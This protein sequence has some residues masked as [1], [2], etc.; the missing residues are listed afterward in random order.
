VQIAGRARAIQN[1]SDTELGVRTKEF[2]DH[3][4][5]VQDS[6]PAEEVRIL[7]VED[8][9]TVA[10]AVKAYLKGAGRTVHH[11]TTA[12]KAEKI[13]ATEPIDIVLL[14][15]ILPD[16]DGR[17]LLVQM[18]E[19]RDTA[20]V[21]VIIMSGMEGAVAKAEC[22]AV[23]AA[24]FLEKP[25]NPK[26]LRAA[27]AKHAR[28]RASAS[29]T[30][31][32]PGGSLAAR[33]DLVESF[34]KLKP[35]VESG[36]SVAAT[37]LRVGDIDQIEAT[38]GEAGTDRLLYAVASRV[39]GSLQGSTISGRWERSDVVALMPECTFKEAKKKV[40]EGLRG[41]PGSADMKPIE[42]AGLTFALGTGVAVAEPGQELREVV[43]AAE[44]ALLEAR[45]S[46]QGTAL[47]EEP[48][49]LGPPRV[50]LVEDDRVTATLI[51][52]RLVREGLEVM[53]FLN[54]ED[55]YAWAVESS[56]DLAILDVKVPGMDGFEL[57][58]RL[59]AMPKLDDVPIV[60]LTGLG[61]E[62]DV[63]RGLEL[64]ANDYML[65][66]FSPTELLARIRRLLHASGPEEVVAP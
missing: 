59:R 20:S 39:L 24:E 45:Q 9:R 15:L 65:K 37:L 32:G 62:A 4:Q 33:V 44:N 46:G 57:L 58:E 51:H 29:E 18:R 61:G 13:L 21:P 43:S 16:R 38:L 30:T 53:D 14:D 23:G 22:L 42:E 36:T 6:L 34:E 60:M 50:L 55:A 5:S 7:L 8:N 66:P 25:V 41:L 48:A 35:M 52:H 1:A 47:K 19:S 3:V 63:V 17:D 26:A 54:G 27:V 40:E 11:A 49:R 28:V 10:K 56:F 12:A 31:V 64:G 2:L